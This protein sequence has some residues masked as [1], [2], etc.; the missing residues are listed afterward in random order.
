MAI[1][2]AVRNL[3]GIYY[4]NP[5]TIKYCFENTSS[6]TDIQK[7]LFYGKLVLFAQNGG[8]LFLWVAIS[9]GRVLEIA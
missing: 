7:T 3:N 6:S 9:R 1:Y 5:K 8:G 2:L 4:L